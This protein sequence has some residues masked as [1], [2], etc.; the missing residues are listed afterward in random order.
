MDITIKHKSGK[1][2]S[3]ADALSRCPS[4]SPVPSNEDQ[5]TESCVTVVQQC[6]EADFSPDLAKFLSY[7]QEDPEM[8][9]MFAYLVNGILPEDDKVS[10]RLVL[11]SKQFEVTDSE[12][13]HE[14]SFVPGRWCLVVPKEL[15]TQLLTEP[16]QGRFAGYLGDRKV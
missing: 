1:C 11:E 5:N 4:D 10:H 9:S 2:N 16:H 3:N 7:Q 13:Y 6:A 14:N 15:R 8:A 12:L